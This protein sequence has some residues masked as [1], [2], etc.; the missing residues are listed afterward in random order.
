MNKQEGEELLATREEIK[1]LREVAQSQKLRTN[2]LKQKLIKA[3]QE[4]EFRNELL[5]KAY[6]LAKLDLEEAKVA[7]GAMLQD[8]LGS[9]QLA[10][11]YLRLI[12]YQRLS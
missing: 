4:L 7:A 11:T 1:I 5:T 12:F 8:D 2:N 10:A 6:I 9:R 3:N